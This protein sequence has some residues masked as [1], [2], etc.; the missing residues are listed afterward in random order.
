MFNYDFDFSEFSLIAQS[1]LLRIDF[2]SN[3][4]IGLP[5][6]SNVKDMYEKE[7]VS[8]RELYDKLTLHK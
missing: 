3:M 7:L 8:L 2:V 1:L 4:L 6:D 5:A